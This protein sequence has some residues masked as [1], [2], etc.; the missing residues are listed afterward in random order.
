MEQLINNTNVSIL[1]KKIIYLQRNREELII[2]FNMTT[3]SLFA[4]LRAY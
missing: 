1:Q 2:R 3:P 4:F